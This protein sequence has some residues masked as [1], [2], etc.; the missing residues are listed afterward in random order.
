MTTDQMNLNDQRFLYYLMMTPPESLPVMGGSQTQFM[1]L[2]N[3]IK[4]LI[5]DKD[6]TIKGMDQHGILHFIHK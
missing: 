6:I 2:G 3:T 1:E 5:V 4:E